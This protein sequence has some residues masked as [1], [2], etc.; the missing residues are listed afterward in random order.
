ME[1]FCCRL[2]AIDM[3]GTLLRPDKTIHPDTIRDLQAAKDAGIEPVYCTGRGVPELKPYLPLLPMMRYAICNSGAVI[4]DLAEAR[5]LH[6]SAV[7]ARY[8][9]RILAEAARYGAMLHYLTGGESI[10]SAQDITHMADFHMGVY[11][12]L[13]LSAARQVADM[14][15]EAASQ[16]DIAKVNLYFRSPE[17]RAAAREALRDLPLMMA[18]QE[19]A[20]LEITAPGVSKA[21]GLRTLA[22]F[23]GIPMEQTMGI[24][25]SDNDIE[26]LQAAGRAV[27]MGNALKHIQRLCDFVTLDNDHNGVGVALRRIMEG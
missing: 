14:A 16:G 15:A 1:Q 25:D 7:R 23:L 11:Q 26:V 9:P 21:S 20:S 6:S 22:G 18:L 10:V 4:Y 13:F 8:L 27:A 12:P 24:G 2:A 19:E 3:D 5:C 17:D